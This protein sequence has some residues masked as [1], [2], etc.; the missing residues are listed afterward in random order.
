MRTHP[1]LRRLVACIL[2]PCCLLACVSWNTQEASPQ[3]VLEDE[4]PDKVRVTLSDGSQVVLEEPVVS[5]DTLTGVAT[6]QQRSIPLAD[7]SALA[8]RKTDASRTLGAVVRG[9]ETEQ[10][11]DVLAR[12][13]H[14]RT[15][16]LSADIE[17]MD[18][19]GDR[20]L[21]TVNDELG[22]QYV[23]VYEVPR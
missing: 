22:V 20:I 9:G 17:V 8:V 19:W 18:V 13:G 4:Q 5:G 2:L 21:G 3:Q 23:V 15:I 16:V 14:V 12:G 7:V 11:W 10:E 1:P 6:G